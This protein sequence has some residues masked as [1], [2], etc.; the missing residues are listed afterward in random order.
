MTNYNALVSAEI[1]SLSELKSNY[2]IDID[3]LERI[4]A[5][6]VAFGISDIINA[7]AG[8]IINLESDEEDTVTAL[9]IDDDSV[10]AYSPT[11]VNHDNRLPS[12]SMLK[13]I[14][15]ITEY[16]SKNI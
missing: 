1:N 3:V 10:I 7:T 13:S 6:S 16:F 2:L 15:T 9:L 5:C 4:C 12:L 14:R 8:N 11:Y